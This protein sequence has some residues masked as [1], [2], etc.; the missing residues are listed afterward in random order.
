VHVNSTP[1]LAGDREQRLTKADELIDDFLALVQERAEEVQG[2]TFDEEQVR[3]F[4]DTARRMSMRLHTQLK[5]LLD[6]DAVGEIADTILD[7]ITLLEDNPA[8]PALDV[9]D[10]L[11]VRA[12]RIRHVIRDVLDA[13]LEC[14]PEDTRA[15]TERLF[16]WLPRVPQADIAELAGRDVRTLQRWAKADPPAHPADRR[17]LLV[18]EAIALLRRAWTP[19][20]VVAWFRRPRRDLGGHSPLEVIGDPAYEQALRLAVRSGRA[21]HGS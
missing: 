8:L 16:S 14:D 6:R 18:V 9:L 15:L 4:I 2:A 13:T 3:Q 5:P 11:L 19:E 21:Q 20:G 17:L 1:H 7:G 12:E 10:D